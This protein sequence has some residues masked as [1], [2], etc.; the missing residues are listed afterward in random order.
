NYLV[1]DWEGESKFRNRTLP[2]VADR[3][4]TGKPHEDISA[5]WI[6]VK[7]QYFT[8]VLS[9]TSNVTGVTYGTVDLSP[10]GQTPVVRGLTAEADV[11]VIRATDGSVSCAF[12]WYA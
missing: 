3:V 1:V 9:P 12:T 2:R 4:K 7:S 6:A 5:G 8:M 10:P 11:P